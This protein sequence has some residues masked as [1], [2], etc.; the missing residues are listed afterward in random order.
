MLR[1]RQ[2]LGK[3]RILGRIASGPL[4]DVY[5]AMDT[6]QKMKV[7][8]KIPKSDDDTGHEE[9]LHEV[10]VATKLKHPNILSVLNA[11]YIDDQFV[12]AMELGD[13][14]LADRIERRISNS[15]AL[16]LAGRAIASLAHAHANKI[17]HCDIKPENF[18]LFPD[19]QL[20]LA[21]F[22]FAKFNLRTLKAS[23]SGTIDYIA[24]E[25][26][27][28]RPKF[29]S[30]VFSL[31]LVVYRL[32]SGSLPEWPFEWP[33]KGHDKLTT[34]VRPEVVELL[35]N[36]IQL[37]PKRRYADAV[38]MQAAFARAQRQVRKQKRAKPKSRTATKSGTSWRQIQWREFQRQFRQ[39][40]QTTHTCR[41]CEGPV[42]ESMQCC[43]WCGFD[44]PA[45]GSESRMPSSCPRCERGVKNDWGY[46]AWCYGPGFVEE[47]SRT[48]PDKRYVA[49]CERERCRGPLMPF[50]RYCPWCRKKVQRPWKLKGSRHR[51]SSC[52][53]GIAR[54][55]WNFCAWCREPVRHG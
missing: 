35:Q 17:I 9:F 31:G 46:C 38:Q 25:Q 40:L 16:D 41:R 2:R 42:A 7:A 10:Q 18:I 27:M 1:A 21:D 33:L 13:E 43:P 30:D 44:N 6:I 55:Y 8:L 32:L 3:Y 34:R 28:G 52:N 14:S 39:T 24:P 20:K 54:G 36:S 19:N 12:I 49:R 23:G 26:A 45:R 15:R 11:S 47:S 22:G 53:W 50:M 37:D 29:Q 48:Y 5:R 51:C 4:A